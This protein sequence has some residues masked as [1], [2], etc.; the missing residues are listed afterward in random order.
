MKILLVIN[1]RLPVRTYGGVERVVWYLAKE[2]D[3][4]G[5]SVTLLAA[6]GTYCPYGEVITLDPTRALYLQIP[7][8]IDVVHFNGAAD[9][10]CKKP[11]VVTIHGNDDRAVFDPR[12][13]IYLSRNHAARHGSTEWVY[14][15]LDWDEYGDVELKRAREY[16]HFLDD[17]RRYKSNVS[18]AIRVV[19]SV[20]GAR[21]KVIG[22]HRFSFGMGMRFTLSPRVSFCGFVGGDRKVSLL[23]GSRGLIYPVLWDEPFGLPII[24]SLYFGAAVFGSQR[25]SLPEIVTSE[26]GVVSNDERALAEAIRGGDFSRQHCHQY[27]TDCFCSRVMAVE[28]IKRYERVMNCADGL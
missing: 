6:K 8:N 3:R 24:E 26:F 25:G 17:A 20:N 28:Y 16:Y 22:G 4:M 18:G 14:N 9:E 19:R 5:H 2:L 27:A 15:G 11:Y 23:G 1:R 21:L 13:S 7:E 10:R 12:R